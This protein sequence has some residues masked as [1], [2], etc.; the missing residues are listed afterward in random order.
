M[1]M[2]YRWVED[3]DEFKKI[4][5]AWDD[6]LK[7][8]GRDDPFLLSDFVLTWWAHCSNGER[9][10]I[11]VITDGGR[12][13]GGIPLCLAKGRGIYGFF[14]VLS[15]VGGVAASYTE[16]FRIPSC[17]TLL[18]VIEEALSAKKDWDVLFLSDVRGECRLISESGKMSAGGAYRVRF[19]QDHMNW[20]IDL[21][22]GRERFLESVSWKLKKDLRAK[23]KHVAKT[24]GSIS[25]RTI[26]GEEDVRRYF[27]LYARFSLQAF[28]GRN[29][30][31]SL[32]DRRYASFLKD[33]MVVMDKSGRLAAHALLGGDRVMAISFGYRSDKGFDWA[34]TAFDYELKYFRPGYLMMEELIK[35]LCDRGGTRCNLYGHERLYKAQWSNDQTPLY[36]LFLFRRG[37]RAGSYDLLRRLEDSLRSNPAVVRMVRR[38]KRA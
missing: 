24:L 2:E 10:R 37:L 29:R 7:Q 38:L 27:D 9:L 3:I 25:L 16:P 6:A 13:V 34:L 19:V 14:R 31:S 23:R 30:K 33:L 1:A 32:E 20:S 21:S 15:Y 17:G 4:A 35:D 11:L 26:S 22:N 5:A 12:I 28:T 18:P 8:S 36:S